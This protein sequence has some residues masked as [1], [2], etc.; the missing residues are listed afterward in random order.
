MDKHLLHLYVDSLLSTF[1]RS[2]AT[3]VSEMVEGEYSHD[4]ITRLL[5]E[6]QLTSRDLWCQVKSVV[7]AIESEYGILIVDDSISHKPHMD[8]N[9]IICWHYDHTSGK[10]VKGIN[11]VSLLY[12]SQGLSI[13]VS[14]R[15]VKKTERVVDSKTGREK[16]VSKES[17]N[18]YFRKML[19]QSVKN[20]QFRYVL[21]DIWYGS[22][23]NMKY[24]KDTLHKNFVMPLKANRKV[25]ISDADKRTGKYVT[26]ETLQFKANE[27]FTVYLEG[28]T[29]PV[30]LV[31]QVFKNKDNSQGVLYLVCSDIT[32]TYQQITDLY[33]KRWKIEEYHKALKQQCALSRSR[34]HTVRTQSSHIFC[35]LCAFVKLELMHR[36]TAVS[37]EG[38]KL[39][40]HLHALKTAFKY[41]RTLQ[42][43]DWAVKPDRKSVV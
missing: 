15:L 14:Y 17:K 39:N 33:Q 37:Y 6:S 32:L 4:S 1:S 21:S 3:S 28:L 30:R 19:A 34:A 43:L 36:I 38:L 40:L 8:E 22:V 9:D 23:D 25:A 2:T 13:P 35:S 42:P 7:R 31:R 20:V 12:H 10:N 5:S 16:R 29:F 41:L 24:I 11:I 18:E 26:V 27:H